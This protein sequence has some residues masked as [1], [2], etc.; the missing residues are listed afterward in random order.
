MS[1]F[2]VNILTVTANSAK[3]VAVL[4]TLLGAM[5]FI[6]G[7]LGVDTGWTLLMIDCM[8]IGVFIALHVTARVLRGMV[9]AGY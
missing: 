6:M 7:R 1:S 8:F 2:V 4:C 9:A 5:F 3:L